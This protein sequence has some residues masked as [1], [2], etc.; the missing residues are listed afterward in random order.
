MHSYICFG[1]GLQTQYEIKY[2]ARQ[3]K[4]RV[5][6]KRTSVHGGGMSKTRE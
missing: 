4:L 1:L 5:N 2:Y 3:E 6:I